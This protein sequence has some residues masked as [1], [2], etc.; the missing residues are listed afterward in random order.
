M[1]EKLI[2]QLKRHEG[3]NKNEKGA[4]TMY[5]CP[6]EKWTIGYGINL[7]EGITEEEAEFLLVSRINRHT[8]EIKRIFSDFDSYPE[9]AKNVLINMHFN[10]GHTKFKQFTKMVEAVKE[11]NW[12]MAANEMKKSLWFRQVGNRGKELFIIMNTL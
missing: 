8:E 2:E 3:S 9:K 7:E 12:K 6:A 10:I 11:K 1:N 5:L 4:H